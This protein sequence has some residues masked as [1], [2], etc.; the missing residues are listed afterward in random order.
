MKQGEG[1][2]WSREL[3]GQSRH[4]PNNTKTALHMDNH[5]MITSEIKLIMFFATE[6]GEALYSQQKQNLELAVTN[7]HE[8]LLQN[9]GLN[10]KK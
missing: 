5:Q 4:P 6:D 1:W 7:N 9:S 10:W 2:V 3:T 8:T